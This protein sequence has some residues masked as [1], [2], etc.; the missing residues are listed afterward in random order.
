[1]ARIVKTMAQFVMRRTKALFDNE[2]R[3]DRRR[4]LKFVVVIEGPEAAQVVDDLRATVEFENRDVRVTVCESS[5]DA[6]SEAFPKQRSELPT[7]KDEAPDG[8]DA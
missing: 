4:G 1:V 7:R 3:A 2:A 5:A 8:C 6:Q